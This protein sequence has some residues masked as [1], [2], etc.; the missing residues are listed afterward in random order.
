MLATLH[1]PGACI[2]EADPFGELRALAET[3][4]AE[5]V[6]ELRQRLP[7]PTGRT[8]LGKGKTRELA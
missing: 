6:G 5:V 7:K 3:A 4:G 2:D 8:F 1:L